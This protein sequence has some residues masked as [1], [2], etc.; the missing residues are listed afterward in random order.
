VERALPAK[1]KVET[2]LVDR[3]SAQE[4]SRMG[5]RFGVKLIRHCEVVSREG[6]A[7]DD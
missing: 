2:T 6:S 7:G 3:I 5:I 4:L 1:A